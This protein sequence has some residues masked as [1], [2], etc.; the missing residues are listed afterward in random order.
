MTVFDQWLA[1]VPG[2]TPLKAFGAG[3][4]L[5][6]ALGYPI[7]A[8]SQQDKQGHD[9]FSQERP[10]AVLQGQER[11]RKQYLQEREERRAERRQAEGQQ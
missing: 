11:A 3:V 1:K 9:Y 6:A 7:F 4:L 10:E 8:N 5:C 2:S